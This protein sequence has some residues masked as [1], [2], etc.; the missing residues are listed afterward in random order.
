MDIPL[1]NYDTENFCDTKKTRKP[2]WKIFTKE[3]IVIIQDYLAD[4]F[5]FVVQGPWNH[6]E[7]CSAL[8]ISFVPRSFSVTPDFLC[9]F[10]CHNFIYGISYHVWNIDRDVARL[11]LQ[12]GQDKE[13][14]SIFPHFPVGSLIF[15]SNLF[16][17][18]LFWSSGR[19]L[20]Q[21]VKF[22]VDGSLH[23]DKT[24]ILSGFLSMKT[25]RGYPQLCKVIILFQY[26]L[27]AGL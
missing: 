9:Y 23:Q 15:Y 10:Q 14:A 21:V 6:T 24:L 7:K 2:L 11:S 12:G 19:A 17:F 16:L 4:I 22:G 8:L 18:S 1:W 3:I 5:S 13:I 20:P 27:L 25:I 26:W